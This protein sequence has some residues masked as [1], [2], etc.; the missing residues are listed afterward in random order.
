MEISDK[1]KAL[2]LTGLISATV[3]MMLFS[4][5]I[6]Q[7]AEKLAE[8]YYLLEPQ[9]EDELDAEALEKMAA[10]QT[11]KAE[12]NKAYNETE[13]YKKFAQ[14]YQPIAPPKDFEFTRPDSPAEETANENNG[15]GSSSEINEDVLSSYNNINSVLKQQQSNPSSQS[16]NKKSSMH[17]SLVNRTHKYLPTPIYLCDDGGKVVVNITVDNK[18]AVIKSTINTAASTDNDCLHEHALE[19]ANE[20]RFNVDNSKKTQLGSITFYFEGKN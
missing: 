8:S 18:G 1:H 7:H 12:T 11:E 13:D 4:F 10:E 6:T 17:Y 9:P 5:Q 15:V 19:Y 3:L 2:L 20:S 16:V 14:A